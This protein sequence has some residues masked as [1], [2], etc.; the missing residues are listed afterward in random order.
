MSGKFSLII[1][2]GLC[3]VDGVLKD[4]DLGIIG[5]KIIKIGK[6]TGENAKFMT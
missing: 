2:N 5:D 6:I 1:K 4:I 3:F